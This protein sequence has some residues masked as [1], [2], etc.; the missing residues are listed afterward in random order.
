MLSTGF[1]GEK[2]KTCSALKQPVGS[3]PAF[4]HV[5]ARCEIGDGSANGREDSETGEGDDN[6]KPTLAINICLES[7]EWKL[8]TAVLTEQSQFL[9]FVMATRFILEQLSDDFAIN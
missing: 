9:A 4:H 6:D 8:L 7:R 2:P 3:L 1:P 5:S